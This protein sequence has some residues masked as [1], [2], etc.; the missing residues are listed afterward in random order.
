MS[1]EITGDSD[2]A[3]HLT[4]R[5]LAEQAIAAEQSG[6]ADEAERLFAAADRVDPEAVITVLQERAN[7]RP[8]TALTQKQDDDEIAAMS[9]T[10]QQHSAAPSR[11]GVSGGGSGGDTQD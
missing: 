5:Q 9:R 11:A 6:D 3:R 1:D 4:A 10:V 7:E 8:A 2:G